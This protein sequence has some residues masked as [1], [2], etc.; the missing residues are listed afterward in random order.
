MVA[1]LGDDD[2]RQESRSHDAALQDRVRQRRHDGH[3]V[4][5]PTLHILG[6]HRAPAQ[7]AGGL[8]VEPFTDFLA[9]APPVLR[10]Y[11]DRLGHDDFLNHRQMLRQP[12][13]A[14]TRRRLARRAPWGLR[15]HG[16]R[17]FSRPVHSLQ[18]QQQLCGIE[19][20]ALRAEELAHEQVDLRFQQ[21]NARMRTLELLIPF[22]KLPG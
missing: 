18:E 10:R 11:L 7:E 22:L 1:I 2:L 6:A 5:H 21:S 16:L 4:Q 12:R 15:G 17:G 3:G 13:P 20:L 14:F 9:D 8:I 19:L